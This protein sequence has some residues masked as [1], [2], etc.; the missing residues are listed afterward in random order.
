MKLILSKYY[1]MTNICLPTELWLN[2][3][4]FVSINDYLFLGIT[5]TYFYKNFFKN[6]IFT[7]EKIL[8]SSGYSR[9][10]VCKF[11]NN[12][13]KNYSISKV[14]SILLMQKLQI[15]NNNIEVCNLMYRY[16]ISSGDYNFLIE[17][18]NKLLVARKIDSFDLFEILKTSNHSYPIFNY[19]ILS[20]RN[21]E[22]ILFHCIKSKTNIDHIFWQFFNRYQYVDKVYIN[23]L[24]DCIL[25]NNRSYFK[26]MLKHSIDIGIDTNY[27]LRFC[28][29]NP[30]I[31]NVY[32]LKEFLHII[33]IFGISIFIHKQYIQYLMKTKHYNHVNVIIETFLK[34]EIPYIYIY[35]IAKY[36]DNDNNECKRILYL[37]STTQ[38][39]LLLKLNNRFKIKMKTKKKYS[40]LF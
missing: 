37:L 17:P 19:L 18:I 25:H 23:L 11:V 38:Q 3:L 10:F 29:K 7:V 2:I 22:S 4:E 30:S 34:T 1:L 28:C 21:T 31:T 33:N 20:R 40:K 16:T 13:V 27:I 32:F 36:F 6:E 15:L 39:D 35:C 9:L 5:S 26:M 8:K 12:L 14:Y 24:L